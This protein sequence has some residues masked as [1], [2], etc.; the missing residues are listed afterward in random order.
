MYIGRILLKGF[1]SFGG[2]HELL[3]PPG[4]TAIVGPNGSGKSNILDA[5][6][7][8]L[9]ETN[10]SRLRIL[11]QNDLLFQGSPS[12]PPSSA[13]EVMIQLRSGS[14]VCSIKRKWIQDEG[15]NLFVDGE[16]VRL[17]D[18]EAV[19]RDWKLESDRFAFIGQGEISEVIQQRPA[20]RRVHLET[21]FGIDLYRKRREDAARRLEDASGELVRLETLKA[22]LQNRRNAIAPMVIQA[23]KAKDISEKLEKAYAELYRIKRARAENII[24]AAEKQIEDF[25]EE[26]RIC[27]YW[28]RG[29]TRRMKALETAVPVLER[30]LEELGGDMESM[31]EKLSELKR[32]MFTSGTVLKDG[33]VQRS[34]LGTELDERRKVLK[35]RGQELEDTEKALQE[36]QK[37]ERYCREEK[38]RIESEEEARKEEIIRTQKE[39]AKLEE[40]KSQTESALGRIRAELAKTGS[41]YREVREGLIEN[42]TETVSSRERLDQERKRHERWKNLLL[43]TLGRYNDAYAACQKNAA[44]LQALRRDILKMET[45]LEELQDKLQTRT[46]PGQVRHLLAA[47]RLGRLKVE[48]TPVAD[49]IDC[50]AYLSSAME[51]FLGGRQY[52]MLVEDLEAAGLCIE[53]LKNAGAGRGTFLPLE[54]ARPRKPLREFDSKSTKVVGWAADLLILEKK[55]ESALLHILGDLLVVEDY[56]TAQK[57]ARSGARFPIVTLEGDVINPSGTVAGG[58]KRKEAGALGIRRQIAQLRTALAEAHSKRTELLESGERLQAE[59]HRAAGERVELEA[60]KRQAAEKIQE[61]ENDLARYGREKQRLEGELGRT[62]KNLAKLGHNFWE[63]R[64]RIENIEKSL[65]ALSM[66]HS[67]QETTTREQVHSRLDVARERTRAAREIHLRVRSERDRMRKEVQAAERNLEELDRR[68]TDASQRLEKLGAEFLQAR[69]IGKDLAEKRRVL[70]EETRRLQ[71][72]EEQ[73]RR[74]RDAAAERLRS[75]SESLSLARQKKSSAEAELAE[76]REMW[77]ERYPYFG[78]GSV[79]PSRFESTRR[80]ARE[81]ETSLRALGDVELGVLSEDTSLKDRLQFLSQQLEDVRQGIKELK[82]FISQTDEQAGKLFSESLKQ[83]E[84]NFCFLFQRLFGGGEAQL[85]LSDGEDVWSAGVE[86]YARPPGKRPQHLGQLSGGEQSLAAISL[87]FASMEVANLPL[88]ILDEVDA[89]LDE[90]NLRRFSE[91]AREYSSRMQLV[92]M[93]HRRVTMERSDVMYGVTLSE[94]GLSQLV[95]VKLEDWD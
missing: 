3:L 15:S 21:L 25:G 47:K 83:I 60:M 30:R 78:S 48:M 24:E 67:M 36:A 5:L 61:L 45:A 31:A 12:L 8:A 63:H 56:E 14:E 85:R 20:Q 51:A 74:R 18:L 94:P 92:C 77:E 42:R 50:P 40:E 23:Q 2:A 86:V 34:R 58:G 44:E 95:S 41:Y 87:L 46:Y 57:T 68:M 69:R 79:D 72:F 52:W 90:V 28:E 16:R 4:M 33:R 26:F 88:G 70:R 55:W 66:P 73:A 38:E 10:P 62:G 22:E 37:E 13:T 35:K 6:R 59:E 19:K 93:T 7:W 27:R 32:E 29:W 1:K 65:H 76:T 82:S 91:L 89:A 64:L 39:A 43:E 53:S 17:Q 80:R 49:A 81:L 71:T 84:K 9:G 11:R 54:Q 75:V